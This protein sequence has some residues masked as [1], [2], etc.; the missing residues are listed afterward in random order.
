MKT[1]KEW[2]DFGKQIY[3]QAAKMFC[4]KPVIKAVIPF[5]DN[6]NF[7]CRVT[8]DSIPT[9]VKTFIDNNGETKF[10]HYYKKS[11]GSLQEVKWG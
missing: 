5:M 9:F 1:E 8:V 7:I 6:D 4:D 3:D 11:D 10:I 2:A